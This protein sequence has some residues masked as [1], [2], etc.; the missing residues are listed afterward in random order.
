MFKRWFASITYIDQWVKIPFLPNEYWS[1]PHLATITQQIG[2]LVKLDRFTLQNDDKAVPRSIILTSDTEPTE[3]FLSYNGVHELCSLCGDKG[4][5]LSLCPKQSKSCIDIIVA[6]MEA[7]TLEPHSQPSHDPN[8]VFVKP[9]RCSKP[10]PYLNG[11]LHGRRP[12]PRRFHK[13]HQHTWRLIP[14]DSKFP[15]YHAP[16]VC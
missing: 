14:L 15:L 1:W 9:Q 5:V 13:S 12:S 11:G 4:H 16:S 3:F 10:R 2:H 8:W 7:N 6:Q